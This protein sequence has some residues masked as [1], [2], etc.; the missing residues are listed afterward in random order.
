ML[1]SVCNIKRT[2]NLSIVKVNCT[3]SKELKV[4]ILFG[5]CCLVMSDCDLYVKSGFSSWKVQHNKT[6]KNS[7]EESVAFT[8]YI[9]DKNAI[10]KHNKRYNE[11]KESF[12]RVLNKFSDMSL[13]QKEG[14]LN[15]FTFNGTDL[16]PYQ[17]IPGLDM[18]R[19]DPPTEI[20]WRAMG[21]VG[22]VQDQGYSCASCW[23]FSALGAL[24]GQVFK[25][26]G[27]LHHLSEQYLIDCNKNKELGNWGCNVS[28]L[29]NILNP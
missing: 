11:G 20:D 15:G 28:V 7:T 21:Y 16:P 2:I 18:E 22:P 5:L 25:T 9:T 23:T 12:L 14:S 13:K 17:N 4:Y 26:T 8:N 1:I 10:D 27:K 24:E 29:Y 6:Y 19:L 3:M